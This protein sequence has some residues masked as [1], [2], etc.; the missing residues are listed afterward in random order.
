MLED[1]TVRFDQMGEYDPAAFQMIVQEAIGGVQYNS[2]ANF[3]RGAKCGLLTAGVAT[4]LV[5]ALVVI[6]YYVFKDHE[7]DEV[8]FAGEDVDPAA[9][10]LGLAA[11]IPP[12][13]GVLT[14][15]GCM[16]KL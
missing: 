1:S 15:M 9:A 5:A 7:R 10:S 6:G 11:V 16:R 4:A 8:R 12:M 2:G 14:W 13:V 3:S